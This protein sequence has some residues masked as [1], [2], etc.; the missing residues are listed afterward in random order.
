MADY[1]IDTSALVKYYHPEDGTQAVTRFIEEPASRHYISRLSLV[2]TV[3][4]FAVKYRMAHINDQEFDDLRR[5]FYYDIGQGRFRI[6]PMTTAR[7]R[8]ATQLIARHFRSRLRTLNAL[9]LAVAFALSQRG[10][11]DHVV[12]ADQTLCETAIEEGLAVIN[13]SGE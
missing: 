3:S 9:Q 12:C 5:R 8:D 11:I 6:M 7:Y 13:P 4:A 2:E 10:M 1:F